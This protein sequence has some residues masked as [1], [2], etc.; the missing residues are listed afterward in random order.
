MYT[1]TIC[2][3]HENMFCNKTIKLILHLLQANLQHII[4]ASGITKIRINCKVDGFKWITIFQIF[5]LSCTLT[6]N[7]NTHLW[8]AQQFNYQEDGYH[9]EAL[10]ISYYIPINTALL[11]LAMCTKCKLIGPACPGHVS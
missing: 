4:N 2:T 5:L 1:G 7:N 6:T 10:Y 11:L 3:L 9:R 8:S